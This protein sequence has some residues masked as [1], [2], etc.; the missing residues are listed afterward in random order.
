MYIQGHISFQFYSSEK[1][2]VS[3]ILTTFKSSKVPCSVLPGPIRTLVFIIDLTSQR[4]VTAMVLI[5]GTNSY[6]FQFIEPFFVACFPEILSL[7]LFYLFSFQ[8]SVTICQLATC[9]GPGELSFFCALVLIP[10]EFT[11]LGHV[12]LDVL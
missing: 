2:K 6:F 7:G 4:H 10:E 5:K 11:G 1:Y 8:T 9:K 12:N 3:P